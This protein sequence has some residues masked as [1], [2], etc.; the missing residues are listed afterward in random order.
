MRIIRN[1]LL[2][3][4][5]LAA[6]TF[7]GIWADW[8]EWLSVPAGRGINGPIYLTI[9]TSL[10]RDL[11]YEVGGYGTANLV[12]HKNDE[13]YLTQS[14]GVAGAT[15]NFL[16]GNAPCAEG[17]GATTCTIV[18]ARPGPYYFSCN[19]STG[20]SCPDPGIQQTPTQGPGKEKAPTL[21][22]A[23]VRD[24]SYIFGGQ[25]FAETHPPVAHPGTNPSPVSP[26]GPITPPVTVPSA[27]GKPIGGY[28]VCNASK[29]TEVN[30]LNANDPPPDSPI[31]AKTGQQISWVSPDT[32]TLAW[33]D[34][35][36]CAVPKP[37]GSP[38]NEAQCTVAPSSGTYRYTATSSATGCA[39]GVTET[40]V[41]N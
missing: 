5:L 1:V 29:K 10:G 28:V 35:G 25:T 20:Y 27:T 24:I 31:T 39:A 34:P 3:F 12:V 38:A 14:N 23:I 33:I 4:C 2:S 9:D 13:I 7:I 16:G 36:L 32:F 18:D 41:V 21:Q 8:S 22:L 11:E 37:G 17:N 6:G 26:V 40:V 19:S 15:M 30:Q